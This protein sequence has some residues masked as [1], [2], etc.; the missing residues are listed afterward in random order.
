MNKNNSRNTD[1]VAVNF[2]RLWKYFPL[3]RSTKEEIKGFLFCMFPILFNRW[4]IFLNWKNARVYRNRQI[5][6]WKK[7]YW[8]RRFNDPYQIMLNNPL[9]ATGEIKSLAVVVHVFYPDIFNE[10]MEHLSKVSHCKMHLYL[11]GEVN[12]LEKINP[13]FQQKFETIVFHNCPNRGRDILPFLMVLPKVINDGHQVVLKLHTKGS[14]HLNRRDH[15]RK[16]LF[17]NLIG[18]G[19]VSRALKIFASNKHIGMVGP[20]GNILPMLNYYGSNAEIVRE[21]SHKLGVND[22]ELRDLNFVAGS[23][24]YARIEALLPL[25]KLDLGKENFEDEAG[26]K[27]GTLAHAVERLFP[28]GLIVANLQLADTDYKHENPVLTINKNHYYTS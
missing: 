7:E 15:W 26:Q 28:V 1:F 25:M 2:D 5:T 17:A 3:R 24:F 20:A 14:N 12:Y 10:I 11:T 4:I 8:K 22:E 9:A 18:D 21:L 23:M 13:S 6:I 19:A 16:H 27:D